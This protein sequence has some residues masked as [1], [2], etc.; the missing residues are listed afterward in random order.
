VVNI[1]GHSEGVLLGNLDRLAAISD[2]DPMAFVLTDDLPFKN[3]NYRRRD[4][5]MSRTRLGGIVL[6]VSAIY[7]AYNLLRA[8]NAVEL[9][10]LTVSIG[11]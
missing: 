5:V 11:G 2:F 3:G 10:I 9:K 7:P 4:D 1:P 6:K 8:V